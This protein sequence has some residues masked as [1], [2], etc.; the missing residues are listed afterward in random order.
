MNVS[1]NGNS[2]HYHS[3][4]VELR[5]RM[6]NGL[7][8]NTSYVYGRGYQSVFYSLRVPTLT[9]LDGGGEGGV[10]HAFKGNWVYEL[11]IGQGRRFAGNV[12]PWMD[13]LI[14]G[15]Q[16]AG[17]FLLRSGQIVDFG[18]VRM[19]GLRRQRS[20]GDV[21]LPEGRRRHRDDAAAGRD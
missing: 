11:P 16:I 7:Q 5:R 19:V 13:R 17:T 1:G 20:E 6:A 3:M 9:Q 21:L 14:G 12:G 4:Q 18:N 2:T 8:F 10:T 15:W